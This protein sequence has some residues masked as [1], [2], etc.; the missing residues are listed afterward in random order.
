MDFNGKGAIKKRRI[1]KF[2]SSWLDKNVFKERLAPHH[3]ENKTMCTACNK[4]IRC[5]KT[6]LLQHSQT[7][8]HIKNLNLKKTFE[9]ESNLTDNNTFS[10]KDKVKQAEIKLAFFAKYNTAFCFSDHLILL[11]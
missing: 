10:H 11:L 1:R 2:Q 8:K 7:A 5:C 4:T 6:N 3:Q 9:V